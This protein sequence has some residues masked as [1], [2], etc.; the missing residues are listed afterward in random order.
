MAD[1]KKNKGLGIPQTRG[2]FQVRGKVSG[3]K[4]EKFFMEKKTKTDKQ[5][6]GVNFGV[7]F[8][9]NTTM[10]VGVN[11]MERDE[12]NFY[13]RSDKKGEKGTTKKVPWRDRFNFKEEGFSLL[14][15]NVGVTKTR[16]EKGDEV[17]KVEHLVEYDA[18][19]TIADN[20]KDGSSVF[21]KGSIEYDVYKEKHTTKF[22]PSQISLCK[23]VDFDAEDFQPMSQFTQDI[24]F[25]SVTPNE[26]KTKA[27]IAAKIVNYDNIQDAE[28]VTYDMGMAQ[29]FKKNLKPYTKINVW[30][31][32]EVQTN[33]EEVT[34]FG[35]WGEENKMTKVNSPTI[36]TLVITG[37]DPE[38]IDTTTYAE[39]ILDEAIAK[40]NANKK[41]EDDFGSVSDGWGSAPF[42]TD[43]DDAGWD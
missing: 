25:M 37:A 29:K 33:N 28:F 18:C 27:T 2:S 15:V 5:W 19:K 43:D 22:T 34:E 42:D 17:N 30:G 12:V 10:F 39:N 1:N 36:R 32:V 21:I 11:G 41:A 13:K 3:A 8:A 23:D 24:V 4:K 40:M 14:G 7:E 6:R 35:G 38:T 20:L 16:N 9:P 31:R 26:D